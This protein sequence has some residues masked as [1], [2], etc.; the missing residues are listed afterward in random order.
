MTTHRIFLIICVVVSC[1]C[2]R[3]QSPEQTARILAYC[4]RIDSVGATSAGVRKQ[5]ESVLANPGSD[6]LN[7]WYQLDSLGHLRESALEEAREVYGA[8]SAEFSKDTSSRDF[9]FLAEYVRIAMYNIDLQRRQDSLFRVGALAG[10]RPQKRSNGWQSSAESLDSCMRYLNLE[11]GW[12]LQSMFDLSDSLGFYSKPPY[13]VRRNNRELLVAGYAEDMNIRTAVNERILKSLFAI[14]QDR[15]NRGEWRK[16]D[17]LTVQAERSFALMEVPINR[18]ISELSRDTLDVAFVSGL[19]FWRLVKQ[20]HSILKQMID[21]MRAY[22]VGKLE[23]LRLK[24]L[25]YRVGLL[26]AELQKIDPAFLGAREA[27]IAH[28]RW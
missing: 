14:Y 26:Y 2:A 9:R 8:T 13:G 12:S 21:T 7:A 4:D 3:G 25:D 10:P 1:S 5:I 15:K 16:L 19:K 24:D 23:G 11:L 22:N 18:L 20:Q 6:S 17:S 28:K 27:Y